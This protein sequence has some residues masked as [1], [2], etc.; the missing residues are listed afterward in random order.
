MKAINASSIMS[1]NPRLSSIGDSLPFIPQG[2]EAFR[3]QSA[4]QQ[5]S[6]LHSY[7]LATNKRI[8]IPAL[9]TS[10]LPNKNN[11]YKGIG[12]LLAKPF[13]IKDVIP[14]KLNIPKTPGILYIYIY[15]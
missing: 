14:S 9:N 6:A 1:R 3:G 2:E 11:G 5:K 15:I 12:Q 7:K 4:L 8:I 10:N 13:T